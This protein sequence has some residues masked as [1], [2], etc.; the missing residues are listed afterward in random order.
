MIAFFDYDGTL[1]RRDSITIC[2]VPGVRRGLISPWTGLRVLGTFVAYKAGLAARE[3]AHRRA[4]EV[5]RDRRID[6]VEELLRGLHDDVVEAWVSPS[7][8]ER[9]RHHQARGDEVV[10]ATAAASVFPR[11]LARKLGI[12]HVLGTELA[13]RGDRFSGELEGPVLDGDAKLARARR[14]AEERGVPLSTCTFYSDHIADRPLLEAV[15]TPVA[16]APH[17]PLAALARERG[18]RVMGHDR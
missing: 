3:T 4:F 15:G 10:I 7:M 6:E 5:Y 13:R 11:P 17:P 18:W 14:F 16:V 12:D 8:V 9:V 2:A 1:V